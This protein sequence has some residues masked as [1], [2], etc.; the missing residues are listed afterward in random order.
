MVRQ[1]RAAGHLIYLAREFGLEQA[2]DDAQLAKATELGAP[3]ATQNQRHF[4]PMHKVWQAD[5][6]THAGILVMPQLDPG[7]ARAWL[8]RAAR[9][10]TP[11]LARNQLMK[12]SMFRTEESGQLF[13][14]SL[15]P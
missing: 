8:E 11:D 6:R 7:R 13:V 12:L 5:G 9:M 15:A 1:L 2:D 4:E 3:L 10:L 14:L